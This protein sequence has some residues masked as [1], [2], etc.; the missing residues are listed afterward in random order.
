M[1]CPLRYFLN[2][3]VLNA[4]CT[5]FDALVGAFDDCPDTLQVH[6]PAAVGYVMGMADAVAE[7]W[8][9]AARRSDLTLDL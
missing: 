2:L 5:N 9:A 4:G 7:H 1:A 6:V 8:A 3:A